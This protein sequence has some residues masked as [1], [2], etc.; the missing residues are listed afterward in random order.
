MKKMALQEISYG[1]YVVCAR[2]ME[3]NNGQIVN[4]LFQVTADPEVIAISINKEN[5]THEMIKESKLFT[6]SILS[7]DTPMKFIGTFG[8]KS[9]RNI[10]K[11]DGINFKYGNLGVPII[12]EH[13]LA[14]LEARVIN[15]M[16]LGSHTI[17]V[18]EVAEMVS[19]GD[20]K[21][22]TY[23]YYHE[24]KGGLSPKTA[25]TYIKREDNNE[26]REKKGV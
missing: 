19:L 18:G 2:S 25:P 17:F 4:T 6:A 8:F 22:M 24:I 11:F 21:A 5:L 15:S 12:T 20:G 9:G 23:S 7:E 13:S 10:D 26:I 16:D 14:C 1:V 3:K